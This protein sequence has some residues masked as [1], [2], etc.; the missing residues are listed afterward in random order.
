MAD[1]KIQRGVSNMADATGTVTITAGSEYTAPSAA[2]KAWI[3]IVST[4]HCSKADFTNGAD[5]L[6]EEETVRIDYPTGDIT[7]D[8]RFTRD[9][10]TGGCKVVWQIIEYT[11]SASGANEFIVRGVGEILTGNTV[12]SADSA[13]ISGISS[14]ADCVPF[15]TTQDTDTSTITDAQFMYTLDMI[16]DG[17]DKVR[18]T[19]G[20]TTGGNSYAGYACV[21][22][23]GS[24]WT[25]QE[26]DHAYTNDDA[27]ETEAINSVGALTRA[28][29][30]VQMQNSTASGADDECSHEV[31]FTSITQ[32]GFYLPANSTAADKDAKIYV[33]SNSQ[34]DGTPMDVQHIDGSQGTG[35]GEPETINDTITEVSSLDI[36]SI[37]GACARAMGIGRRGSHCWLIR[38]TTTTNVELSRVETEYASNYRFSVVEWPTIAAVGEAV[39]G[40]QFYNDEGD[41]DEST[42]AVSQDVDHVIAVDG[43]TRI[44]LLVETPTGGQYRL[45]AAEDGT[46]NWFPIANPGT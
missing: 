4:T 3:S 25:V 26:I 34:T 43:T 32:L 44:R 11:G 35:G 12:A 37:Q 40:Y 7:D 8:V 36:T 6:G 9:A 20:V 10:T 38:P 18:A 23:T 24:N 19:R 30:E 2:S 28:F 46:E 16:N 42:E 15:I 27:E 14:V 17:D 5:E 1:F 31:Y 45:E 13:A 22:F 33:V 29:L 41:E 21:E 39:E